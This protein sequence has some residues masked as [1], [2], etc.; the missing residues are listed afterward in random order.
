MQLL[1]QVSTTLK[2]VYKVLTTAYVLTSDFSSL[3]GEN[4]GANRLRRNS[5]LSSL[6]KATADSK[7]QP[8]FMILYIK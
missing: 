8:R 7:V 6:A 3:E 4:N 5:H 1:L 2:K